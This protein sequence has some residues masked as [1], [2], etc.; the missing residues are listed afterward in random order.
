VTSRQDAWGRKHSRW[1]KGRKSASA[2]RRQNIDGY[3][4]AIFSAFPAH[5]CIIEPITLRTGHK[6]SQ[7][8]PSIRWMETL[9]ER[10]PCVNPWLGRVHFMICTRHAKAILTLAARIQLQR[11]QRDLLQQT[12]REVRCA[13]NRVLQSAPATCINMH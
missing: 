5:V 2:S 1:C 3:T 10:K 11:R 7:I 4:A 8:A 12:Q 9:A 13:R 6:R